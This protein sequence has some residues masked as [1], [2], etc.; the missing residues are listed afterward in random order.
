MSL[1]VFVSKIL[2]ER[3]PEKVYKSIEYIFVAGIFLGIIAMFQPWEFRL[4]KIGFFVLFIALLGFMVWS[5][6]AM[7]RRRERAAET[8]SAEI[9]RR[10]EAQ[11]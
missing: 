6:L 11:T 5:H 3:V 1:I 2:H 10:E 9:P 7:K 8:E 4:F